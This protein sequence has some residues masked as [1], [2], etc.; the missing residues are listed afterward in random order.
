MG[1]KMKLLL[2]WI[3]ALVV[4]IIFLPEYDG[5]EFRNIPLFIIIVSVALI[6]TFIKILRYILFIQKIKNQLIKNGYNV[7][8]TSLVP[9]LKNNK[10]YHLSGEKDS[11]AVN[12]YIAKRKNSYVT[13]LFENEN[14]AELYKHT[15]LT[16]KPEVRQAYIISPHVDKKKIGEIYFFWEEDDFS[17]NAENILLFKK[18][19][20][21]V[22]DTKSS[23][24]LDNGDK[25]NGK[26]LLFDING[27]TKYIN[28]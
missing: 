17:E 28:N 24:P 25:I 18:M 22:K 8:Q 3:V 27:F 2:C 16:I 7:T 1:V 23:I 14:K 4:G 12:I 5:G 6:L 9:N 15:R 11:K 26:V 20:N 13:Y 19:P 21:N 10:C